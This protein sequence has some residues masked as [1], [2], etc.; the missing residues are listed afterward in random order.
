MKIAL[1]HYH[2]RSGGVSQVV[3]NQARALTEAGHEALVISGEAPV[4]KAGWEGIGMA[5]VPSLHYDRYRPHEADPRT[6]DSQTP[7]ISRLAG[8]VDKTLRERWPGGPDIVHVHNPLIRKNSLFIG[9]LKKLAESW[10]LLLQ[11]HDLAEDFRP[12]VY[13]GEE[14]P[15]NCHFAVIN[16]RDYR[17]LLE[18][19]LVPEGLHLLPNEVRELPFTPGLPKTRYLYPVRGIRRK[20]IG[21]MLLLSL[22]IG[23]ADAEHRGGPPLRTA[24]LTQPPTTDQDL[25]IY[26]RWKEA[27]ARLDLPVE[28]ETGLGASFADVMGSACAVLTSSVKEGFGFSFL[29]P[30]T[31]G[32]A[33]TGRYIDYVCR[34]FEKEGLS[35]SSFYSSLNI[36]AEY[37]EPELLRQKI[38]KA[39]VRIY[40]AFNAV[41]P[42]PV[43]EALAKIFR[44]RDTFDFGIM[45]EDIQERILR[46]AAEDKTFRRQLKAINPFLE[47][48]ADRR[49]DPQEIE[50][51]RRAVVRSYSRSRIL[52]TL[53]RVYEQVRRPVT[54]SISRSKLL[55]QYLDPL[56]LSL[57]GISPED[58]HEG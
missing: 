57:V 10:P 26:R 30:W 54:Q 8:T 17:F 18:A 47:S 48:L 50:D 45:D 58:P 5:F 56:R 3:L 34:D 27:A 28:F 20:N 24:A 41:L 12:D 53:E 32:L 55:E 42:P 15:E 43:P 23:P 39:L 4:Y 1:L 36:P 9:A 37:A 21:E 29:E 2:L 49:E 40:S 33:V 6:S 7:E 44:D 51:N 13:A 19:G 22:F 35:F 46:R 25:P 16:S 14:Y 38:E 31:A 11:N 52:E